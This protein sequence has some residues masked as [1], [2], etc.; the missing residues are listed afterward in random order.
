MLLLEGFEGEKTSDFW[1]QFPGIEAS[2]LV[3]LE[4]ELKC[5]PPPSTPWLIERRCIDHKIPDFINGDR[6]FQ[7]TK[8]NFTTTLHGEEGIVGVRTFH[9]LLPA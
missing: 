7:L 5:P 9:P 1:P 6:H 4:G 8:T 2:L 3:C